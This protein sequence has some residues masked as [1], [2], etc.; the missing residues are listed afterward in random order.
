MRIRALAARS[1]VLAAVTAPLAQTAAPGRVAVRAAVRPLPR[2]RRA[3]R[4]DG[5][6]HRR[7]AG[8]CGPTP[9]WPRSCATACRRRACPGIAAPGRRPAGA[10]RASRGRCGPGAATPPARLQRRDGR[11]RHACTASRS[12]ARPPTCSSSPTT[13]RLHLLRRAGDALAPRHLAGRLADLPRRSRRQPL[14]PARPDQPRQRRAP[15]AGV[16]VHAARRLAA[17]R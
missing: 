1:C 10:G 8:R 9:S 16:D 13:A 5:T 17:C 11:R 7:A 15:R 3:R 4:R 14:Q 12:T 6:G 2:R